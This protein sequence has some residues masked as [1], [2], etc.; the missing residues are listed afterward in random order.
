MREVRYIYDGRQ[1][2]PEEIARLE[3]YAEKRKLQEIEAKKNRPAR[4]RKIIELIISL[5]PKT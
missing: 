4:L 5:R 2:T 1:L 3:E